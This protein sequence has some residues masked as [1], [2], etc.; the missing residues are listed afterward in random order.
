MGMGV[1]NSGWRGSVTSQVN[2]YDAEEFGTPLTKK[3][4]GRMM[5]HSESRRPDTPEG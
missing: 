4:L 1:G 3:K 2:F 5:A